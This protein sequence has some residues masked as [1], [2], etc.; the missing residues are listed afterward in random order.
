LMLQRRFTLLLI[1][2]EFADAGGMLILHDL[3]D[4]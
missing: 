3:S 4:Q 1:A 2:K